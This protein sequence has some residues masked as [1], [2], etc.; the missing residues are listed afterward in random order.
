MAAGPDN[1]SSPEGDLESRLPGEPV[2]EGEVDP[3]LIALPRPKPSIGP[4]LSLSVIFL[5]GLLLAKLWP[6]FR[7]TNQE[8][9]QNFAST[10]ELVQKGEAN[11]FVAVRAVP[12]LTTGALVRKG[13]GE[14]GHRIQPILGTQGQF[15]VMTH[16]YHWHATPAYSHVFVGR[17]AVL[18]DLPF[19]ETLSSDWRKR[20]AT[21][22]V[23]DIET[24]QKALTSKAQS[25]AVIGGDEVPLD[26]GVEL[27]LSQTVPQTVAV[28]TY[29][30]DDRPDAEIWKLA[31]EQAGLHIVGDRSQGQG[32]SGETFLF[33]VKHPDGAAAVQELLASKRIFAARAEPVVREHLASFSS[34]KASDE[35]LEL[36]DGEVIPWSSIGLARVAAS[37]PMPE[38]AK[39]LIATDRPED[40]WYVTSLVIVLGISGLFFC[41]VLLFPLWRARRAV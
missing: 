41:F 14:Y 9:P 19:Y 31:L 40:Y 33:Q 15:W 1:H 7:F 32:E 23:V 6:D 17:L 5:C 18:G 28:T 8:Q 37:Y 12:D 16:S 39:V 27:E 4:L 22:R 10:A 38:D 21:R 29:I 36:G 2:P 35:A 34:L 26:E 3:E 30:T 20:P 24:L 25:V 11:S 13:K